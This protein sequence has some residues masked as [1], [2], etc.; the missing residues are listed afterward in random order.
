MR[1]D[2][3]KRE[4]DGSTHQEVSVP[5][6]FDS[7]FDRTLKVNDSYTTVT[8]TTDKFGEQSSQKVEES[9]SWRSSVRLDENG[10]IDP[11][12][13]EVKTSES[14]KTYRERLHVNPDGDSSSHSADLH[15]WGNHWAGV[16]PGD[17]PPGYLFPEWDHYEVEY[18]D[19][20]PQYA[21]RW[22]AR[23]HYNFDDPPEGKSSTVQGGAT[24]DPG[25]VSAA[26]DLPT[27]A[28]WWNPL[29]LVQR[30]IYADEFFASDSNYAAALDGFAGRYNESKASAH[31]AIDV[32][33]V[34]DGTPLSDMVNV[35]F[36][37]M[38]GDFENAKSTGK[39]ALLGPVGDF[40]RFLRGAKKGLD[41]ATEVSEQIGKNSDK[42]DEIV[43]FGDGVT[44]KAPEVEDS[45][46]NRLRIENK[47][48]EAR[49][50]ENFKVR[51]R[52]E[53]EVQGLRD[54]AEAMKRA[55]LSPEEIARKLN[56]DRNMLKSKYRK[57]SPADEVARFEQRNIEKYGDPLGPSIE[58]LRS[59]G[60]SWED[61]IEGATRPG[62]GDLGF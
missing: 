5:D 13:G 11:A 6:S 20:A 45:I 8:T 36:Y 10:R 16:G 33:S 12:E 25:R 28:S 56:V 48:R 3:T 40:V 38:E 44:S 17:P 53:A 7:T 54:T 32:I 9:V 52:Y 61:I 55:G 58:W 46:T 29:D 30:K 59:H 62:G 57:L 15:F 22:D 43:E 50:L 39:W 49:T 35:T 18:H 26:I 31:A 37:T 51:G 21:A 34:A 23:A 1:R 41:A 19:D 2:V 27:S 24:P 47:A 60:K 4:I 14:H 42:S